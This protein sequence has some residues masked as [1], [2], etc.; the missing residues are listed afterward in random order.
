VTPRAVA[1]PRVVVTT[2]WDDGHVLDLVVATLLEQY[3]IQGTFYVAPNNLEIPASQRLD[4][5][6]L[7]YIAE[8]FEIGAHTLTHQRLSALNDDESL[9]EITAGKRVLEE[10]IGRP[11]RSFC[12]PGGAYTNRHVRLVEVAGFSVARTVQRYKYGPVEDPLTMPTT[13]HAYRHLVDMQAI[14]RL[15]GMQPALATKLFWN[16]DDLAILPFDRTLA[17]GGVFHLW[18]HSWEIN[19]HDS[20]RRLERVLAYMA[21]RDGVDYRTNGE[22]NSA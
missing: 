10:L 13:V 3:R 21:G 12:Y 5:V 11:V 20:W 22:V 4:R 17:S 19:E 18:G 6:S 1:P 16:W 15:V 14:I 2:S 8:R 9:H 7:R